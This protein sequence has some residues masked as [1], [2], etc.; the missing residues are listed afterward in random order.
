MPNLIGPD[1]LLMRSRYDEALKLRG[2]PAKYQHP[3]NP[4]TNESGDTIIDMYSPEEDVYIFLESNPKVKTLKRLGWVVDTQKDQLPMIIHVSWNTKNLQRD[5]IFSFSGLYANIP[6][7]KFRVT[8]IT[9]DLECPDH[10]VCKVVP[11]YDNNI[12]GRTDKEV[13]QTFNKSNKFIRNT[14]DY[15]GDTYETAEDRGR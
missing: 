8:E 13:A 10:L 2:I 11:V 14:A 3:L 4:T 7:R 5:S 9:Y 1:I 15:R 6:D 12:V